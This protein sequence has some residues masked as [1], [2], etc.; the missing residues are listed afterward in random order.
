MA[1]ATSTA[2]AQWGI[3]DRIFGL[4]DAVPSEDLFGVL[5]AG[6]TWHTGGILVRRAILERTGLFLTELQTAEDCHLWWRM[7]MSGRIQA[8]DL[9]RPTGVYFRHDA[10]SFQMGLSARRT[11]IEALLDFERWARA[12]DADRAIRASIHHQI[13]ETSVRYY[14]A[15]RHAGREDLAWSAMRRLLAIRP[16]G[17]GRRREVIRCVGSLMKRAAGKAFGFSPKAI[18]RA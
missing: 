15:A 17:Y 16:L 4:A 13:V 2:E 12:R 14:E 9:S 7:A 3:N 11:M 18:D 1:F 10:N 5:L 6:R 8:G